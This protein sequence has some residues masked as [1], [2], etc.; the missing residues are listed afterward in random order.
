MIQ[1]M[2][3]NYYMNYEYLKNNLIKNCVHYIPKI[4]F[5]TKILIFYQKEYLIFNQ[6]KINFPKKT[7]IFD[8]K[9]NFKSIK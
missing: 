8:T 4:N 5:K 3:T 9:K 6:R 2:N 1:I 7:E